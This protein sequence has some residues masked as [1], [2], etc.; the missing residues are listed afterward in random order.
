MKN[1]IKRDYD[2]TVRED[3]SIDL[4]FKA[5][6]FL[7]AGINT[8]IVVVWGI[9]VAVLLM[10]ISPKMETVQGL[11]FFWLAIAGGSIYA[12]ISII[13]G[14]QVIKIHPKK[15]IEFRS[16]SIPFSDIDNIGTI[17]KTNKQNGPATLYVETNGSQVKITQCKQSLAT[18]LKKEITD[19]SGAEWG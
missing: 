18:A 1:T 5:A 10:N 2:R 13:R 17:F 9:V 6:R 3:G 11:L 12:L 14:T 8:F 4:T 19:A 16:E 15:G 7:D